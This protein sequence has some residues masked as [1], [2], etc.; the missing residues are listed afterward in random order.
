MRSAPL[1]LVSVLWSVACSSSSDVRNE[2]PAWVN[3]EVSAGT[4]PTITWTPRC[5]LDALSVSIVNPD[6]ADMEPT[7]RWRIYSERASTA[8]NTCSN[9]IWPP[10]TYG[11]NPC[12]GWCT[13]ETGPLALEKGVTYLVRL[14]TGRT[15]DW[16][17]CSTWAHVGWLESTP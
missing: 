11:E 8:G 1:V 15:S 14:M 2:C 7:L 13:T 12:T 16:S 4:A 9:R 10:V 6:S 5:A 3:V 17:G